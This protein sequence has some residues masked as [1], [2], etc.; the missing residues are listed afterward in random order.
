MVLWIRALNKRVSWWPNGTSYNW[1]ILVWLIRGL[2]TSVCVVVA[3]SDI[4]LEDFWFGQFRA[5][6][7]IMCSVAQPDIYDWR[8]LVW[9]IRALLSSG[10]CNGP[11]G[12]YY[13]WIF[14]YNKWDQIRPLLSGTLSVGAPK[15]FAIS[16]I[17][18]HYIG[19]Y[20]LSEKIWWGVGVGWG[21][22][23]ATVNNP[24]QPAGNSGVCFWTLVVVRG[25]SRT[26]EEPTHIH[27]NTTGGQRN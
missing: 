17:T 23:S 15:Q 13:W 27:P 14:S 1:R 20:N 7:T 8:I 18:D 3:R 12:T 9:S 24:Q 22:S 25:M 4:L 11:I 2:L 6:L 21:G 26:K 16:E 10:V 5:L 19:A